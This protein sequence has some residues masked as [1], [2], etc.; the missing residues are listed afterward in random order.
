MIQHD[1]VHEGK[2]SLIT[3]NRPER[4]N[5]LDP[6]H[7]SELT[8]NVREAAQG[9]ARVIVITGAGTAFCAG[10][11]LKESDIAVM[12]DLLEKTFATIREVPVPVIAYING[13]AVGAG[14]QLAVSCDLR[15]VGPR[16]RL[17]VPAAAISLPVSPGT[18]R[19]IVALAGSGAARAMLIGG[20]WIAAERA[21]ALGL[22]DRVGELD[23]AVRWAFEIAGY[24]PRLL[25]YFKEQLQVQNLP[26]DGGEFSA[27][28][29]WVRETED[30][31]ESVTARMEGR[32][33]VYTGR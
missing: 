1:H 10:G 14:A 8:S 7:W 25:A 20:D 33:P 31:T 16:G 22:A 13:A 4:R 30:Y 9:G 18:I 15:V 24:A 6:S 21:H 27:A 2:V 3:L 23:D 19:R 28:I 5:A 12:A 11:D 32:A 17:R 26:T 29:G